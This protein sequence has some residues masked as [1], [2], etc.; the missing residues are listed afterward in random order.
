MKHP[1][2]SEMYLYWNRLRGSRLLPDRS[3]IE[4][5]D[6]RRILKDTFILEPKEVG[7]YMFRLAGTRICCNFSCELKSTNMLDLI[8]EESKEAVH[9]ILHSAC[10]DNSVNVLG[11]VGKNDYG[12]SVALETILLPVSVNNTNQVRLIGTLTA[13]KPP[14]WIGMNPVRTLELAS[15][16]MVLPHQHEREV[17][18]MLEQNQGEADNITQ[19]MRQANQEA[20]MAAQQD[21]SRRVRHLTVFDGGMSGQ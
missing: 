7:E 14:Y 8:G 3:D 2:T 1:N 4:P 16:R 12:K 11:F 18:R 6:I 20:T 19:F 5:G 10:E 15:F 17:N 21:G 9:T 13:I